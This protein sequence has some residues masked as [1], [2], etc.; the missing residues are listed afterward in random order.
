MKSLSRKTVLGLA[1]LAGLGGVWA[2]QAA[3]A[4]QSEAAPV[5]VSVSASASGKAALTVTVVPARAEP[6]PLTVQANGSIAAWQEAVIGAEAQ[7]LRLVELRAQ[8]G[9]RVA[10]G[11]LLARLQSDTLTADLGVSRANLVEAQATLAEA[12]AN[13]ERARQL[14]PSG[15]VSAQQV[16]QY[17][18]GEATAQARVASAQARVAADE[19]RL[20][21][22]RILAPDAGVVSARSA[23]LG[24]V[25]QP[26][27]ELFR[28]IRQSRLEW[29]A[30]LP[31]GELARIR[32]GMAAELLI[33]GGQTLRGKVRLVA[34]TVDTSSRNGLVYVD[35]LQSGDAK[36]GMFA[37]GQFAFGS[38][39]AVSLP[40]T[41]VV[42]RDG[43]N[44]LLQ[45]QP[46]QRL[47]QLKVEV[48]RRQGDRIEIK[49][50]LP[51]GAN[52]VAQGGGFLADGDRVRV[53]A[54]PA[55]SR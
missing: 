50:T 46:D 8:V 6:W 42:M 31:A 21:Q 36:P 26:G 49:T 2:V 37:R 17:L 13:A 44:Y 48:G 27:T 40:Q 7:G 39:P 10:K 16:Q 52:F 20:A 25:V 22:T 28:L 14:Q 30:E 11:A 18:T 38:A 43:F 35:L 4:G 33:P 53:V 34:P 45:V 41:A 23:T 5:S 19:V 24:S 55:A 54:A 29:R 3:K 51:T 47:R 32:P 9:D 12:R 15:A 1:A